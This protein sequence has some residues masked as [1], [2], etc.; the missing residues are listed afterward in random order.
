MA[1]RT[2][3]LGNTPAPEQDKRDVNVP[4]ALTE[5]HQKQWQDAGL[6][7]PS[8]GYGSATGNVLKI[9]STAR[10][11]QL[12]QDAAL[13]IGGITLRK[14]TRRGLEEDYPELAPA[15][16][17][18]PQL[19]DTILI[20]LVETLKDIAQNQSQG[21]SSAQAADKLARELYQNAPGKNFLGTFIRTDSQ[22]NPE[23]AAAHEFIRIVL[24]RELASHLVASGVSLTDALKQAASAAAVLRLHLY[25]DVGRFIRGTPAPLE[26]VEYVESSSSQKPSHVLATDT[27]GGHDDRTARGAGSEGATAGTRSSVLRGEDQAKLWGW[28]ERVAEEERLKRLRDKQESF[29]TVA[30]AKEAINKQNSQLKRDLPVD[31]HAEIKGTHFRDGP[32]TD[33]TVMEL[34]AK[35]ANRV[36]QTLH[37][38]EGL[39]LDKARAERLQQVSP[40]LVSQLSAF[41][42]MISGL[43]GDEQA[44][45]SAAIHRGTERERVDA[46]VEGVASRAYQVRIQEGRAGHLA[47]LDE[48]KQFESAHQVLV[49]N[50]PALASITHEV[51]LVAEQQALADTRA[52]HEA[53]IRLERADKSGYQC[54]KALELCE[55]LSP[56][57]YRLAR[58]IAAERILQSRKEKVDTLQKGALRF[59]SSV[60]DRF[61]ALEKN[62]SSAETVKSF[63]QFR[64]NNARADTVLGVS[65]ARD[66]ALAL[67][68]GEPAKVAAIQLYNSL[69][70]ASREIAVPELLASFYDAA[71]RDE[72]LQAY[73]VM[74]KRDSAEDLAALLS[75]EAQK[76]SADIISGET[77]VA[78]P[79]FF[80]HAE[81]SVVRAARLV[82]IVQCG[83]HTS[84]IEITRLQQAVQD[85]TSR[86]LSLT[87][88]PQLQ[89]MRQ[90]ELQGKI[91]E[92]VVV[93]RAMSAQRIITELAQDEKF[94]TD[95]EKHKPGVAKAD[96]AR[97]QG[98]IVSYNDKLQAYIKAD[99]EAG[100]QPTSEFFSLLS[101]ARE[102]GI[103]LGVEQYSRV[104]QSIE[105]IKDATIGPFGFKPW[106]SNDE[107]FTTLE[108]LS[109]RDLYWTQALF[110]HE[111][112]NGESLRSLLES[113]LS[114][115]LEKRADAI[116]RGDTVGAALA[117]AR[118][119]MTGI[120]VSDAASTR[121]VQVV[122]RL[123]PAA[124]AEF[125][126]RLTET[127]SLDTVLQNA[128]ISDADKAS[129]RAYLIGNNAE[130]TLHEIIKHL[131]EENSSAAV[132]TLE[133]YIGTELGSARLEKLQELDKVAAVVFHS[134]EERFSRGS[135][136]NL[137]S[138]HATPGAAFS[139]L[140]ALVNHDATDID[141]RARKAA[142]AF[143]DK[144]DVKAGI[145]A[146]AG[147]SA[148]STQETTEQVAQVLEHAKT[149]Y[150]I[151]LLATA[152]RELS[153]DE[154]RVL[155]SFIKHGALE[156]ID[157]LYL[158]TAGKY[159]TDVPVVRRI[160]KAHAVSAVAADGSTLTK[161]ER[162]AQLSARYEERY[163]GK[164]FGKTLR[165]VLDGELTG[166][167]NFEV[168]YLYDHG[169][170]ETA[171][172]KFSYAKALVHFENPD[173]LRP[174]NVVIPLM[175][176]E[177]GVRKLPWHQKMVTR[178]EEFV[179]AYEQALKNGEFTATD[180]LPPELAT[181]YQKV[182]DAANR[183]R[184][185]NNT[186]ADVGADVAGGAAVVIVVVS[187]G[188]ASIPVVIGASAAAGGSARLLVKT[189]LKGNS[190]GG[191]EEGAQIVG[192]ALLADG[193][194]AGVGKLIQP[195]SRGLVAPLFNRG[196]EMVGTRQLS[197]ATQRGAAFIAKGG[198]MTTDPLEVGMSHI[199]SK[200]SN[201]VLYG[202]A[203][204]IIDGA[205]TGFPVG[206]GYAAIDP[207]TW[208]HGF[209]KGLTRVVQSGGNAAL[210][211]AG[212]GGVISGTTHAFQRGAVARI[213]DE[214]SVAH[215]G[216]LTRQGRTL[217]GAVF[218]IRNINHEINRASKNTT[219]A[220]L[221]RGDIPAA[222]I[223][224]LRAQRE[225]QGFITTQNLNDARVW[226]RNEREL[227]KHANKAGIATGDIPN[228]VWSKLARQGY[229]TQSDL[230]DLVGRDLN[231]F[232][233]VLVKDAPALKAAQKAEQEA[234]AAAARRKAL[235]NKP[236]LVAPEFERVPQGHEGAPSAELLKELEP[237]RPPATTASQRG[238]AVSEGEQGATRLS[239]SSDPSREVASGVRGRAPINDAIDFG[240]DL[241]AAL[242]SVR[243][244]AAIPGQST[245]IA[246]SRRDFGTR[247]GSS[248]A[249][250]STAAPRR[251]IAVSEGDQGGTR[252]PPSSD[253]SRE[254]V[255]GVRGRAPINDAI[256]FGD[257]LNKALES[258]R[259]E[260]GIP[261]QSTG[262]TLSR[263]DLGTR[264]GSSDAQPSTAAPRRG[265]VVSEGDQ[266]AT[267]LPPSSDPSR[268]VVSGV[269]GRSLTTD[270][271]DL[272]D[273]LN[274]ALESVRGEPAIPLQRPGVTSSRSDLGTRL[275]SSDAQP[276]TAAPRRGVVV[277]EGD[278]GAT[279]L[280]PSD[281]SREVV[282]GVRGRSLTT[283]TIE[284]GDDLN[285]ALES[286]RGEAAA[287]AQ[288]PGV[289]SSRSDLGTRLGSS[290]AQP[291]PAD[292]RLS[293][294][295]TSRFQRPHEDGAIGDRELTPDEL[296]GGTE[297]SVEQA[298]GTSRF[299]SSAQDHLD[300][301]LLESR[302]ASR[303]GS[304][305]GLLGGNTRGSVPVP[306]SGQ[307]MAWMSE[308]SGVPSPAPKAAPAQPAQPAAQS[309]QPVQSAQLAP[310]G[311][312]SGQIRE[313]FYLHPEAPTVT[314]VDPHV[315]LAQAEEKLNRQVYALGTAGPSASP[316]AAPQTL[317]PVFEA[318]RRAARMLDPR[319]LTAAAHLYFGG[320]GLAVR[321]A[322]LAAE[323]SVQQGVVLRVEQQASRAGV[324]SVRVAESTTATVAKRAAAAEQS[325]ARL[326]TTPQQRPATSGALAAQVRGAAETGAATAAQT[327]QGASGVHVVQRAATAEQQSAARLSRTPQ[328]RPATSDALPT[329]VRGAE[330]GAA[331]AQQ[332]APQTAVQTAQG[333]SGAQA[334]QSLSLATVQEDA[335]R[336]QMA[337]VNAMVAQ[338]QESQ[339][340]A[341]VQR[342]QQ[343]STAQKAQNVRQ[344]RVPH[345][346]AGSGMNLPSKRYTTHAEFDSFVD[347]SRF[348]ITIPR[349]ERVVST[350][351]RQ[352]FAYKFN[353]DGKC[354]IDYGSIFTR[355]EFETVTS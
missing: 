159:G 215:E 114:D 152:E 217:Q 58:E 313:D 17:R 219:A 95:V 131:Q 97:I 274:K 3:E 290:D 316:V 318:M 342:Q 300:D 296:A 333:A 338:Q 12:H 45:V 315:V 265:V 137:I 92:A 34:R 126:A 103:Q 121:V 245:G 138:K 144:Q 246:S 346:G 19:P 186:I 281:P 117:E 354:V 82:G 99:E 283:D 26:R 43:S 185:I 6:R 348:T 85:L 77:T 98:R 248:D 308:V 228:A 278:Q 332:A 42:E 8:S 110:P 52:V 282:S 310:P 125:L 253:P 207:S 165:S 167:D 57:H 136:R 56:M 198:A 148:T 247:L 244:E 292:R 297:L 352:R 23:V 147:N 174:R 230:S 182:V 323:H 250:P 39:A 70:S 88:D 48:L 81:L 242:E 29:W 271:I 51:K 169:T 200:T 101:A 154:N 78:D 55:A 301:L 330:T 36:L 163:A 171:E 153:K 288:R 170:P 155:N 65:V 40:E 127:E 157:A 60:K 299:G 256:D 67:A 214:A 16:A 112:S 183:K 254:V 24:E 317:N 267:R 149:E 120:Y 229:L 343:S 46:F 351:S 233:P 72:A 192:T 21:G 33:L 44:G 142:Y 49:R 54:S 205:A 268:E 279:R 172:E 344:V 291:L 173:L 240:D 327:A 102:R 257:D 71:A 211:G 305:P 190:F 221:S 4:K 133:S 122:E 118:D 199:F 90:A 231:H 306:P 166:A 325:A 345:F 22:K 61:E 139:F 251:G 212:I 109:E 5:L 202:A 276:S 249:Q 304:Q 105:A 320:E 141:L 307:R 15:L 151:D 355:T 236:P 176:S 353:E 314:P 266:G 309:A 96:L 156:D 194:G 294:T 124:R 273:D 243:A 177:L 74:F 104:T 69:R 321:S 178:Q 241:N 223:A 160:I 91:V 73:K 162:I 218:N 287:P 161:Q 31:A 107:L 123:S 84:E 7:M 222:E 328:Q 280:P 25:A 187:T 111:M 234:A 89:T 284:L 252:L 180:N 132:T 298:L 335:V 255:S 79:E 201:R 76:L 302:Y 261:G 196:A 11:D 295:R 210:I 270:T 150:H 285:K 158:A 275:G 329:Q 53:V 63:A 18:M 326:R 258:V 38:A 27:S 80:N 277:S 350:V 135:T 225:A 68:Q 30:D 237:F 14:K 264:L 263:R 129:V 341:Q 227:V 87:S 146:L 347:G 119:A 189:S 235:A 130:A 208:E 93:G 1:T 322:T 164:F 195:L 116:L 232:H 331:T 106:T 94:L 35:Y 286:V 115:E 20:K 13:S 9:P 224:R 143:I 239:P 193:L 83:E 62:T 336:N 86:A 209:A 226:V 168:L 349:K 179:A 262:A 181:Q 312:T 272:G 197:L 319:A 10:G 188:G 339:Q 50:Y 184:G 128:R 260:V 140:E 175:I 59:G 337:V 303:G 108:S 289:T 203:T 293:D 37:V 334:K 206:A 2:P 66:T 41:Q 324:Q 191:V 340:I 238:I 113:E 28:L 64:L 32:E 311:A 100:L 259:G 75:P 269:R 213:V 134:G 47:A 204:G 216:F 145:A 220:S